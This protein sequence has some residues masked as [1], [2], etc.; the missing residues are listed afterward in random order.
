MKVAILSI[1][2]GWFRVIYIIGHIFQALALLLLSP[3]L[4]VLLGGTW[5]FLSRKNLHQP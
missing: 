4:P 3:R 5:V 1:A 2:V